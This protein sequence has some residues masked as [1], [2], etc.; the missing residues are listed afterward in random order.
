M[1]KRC[2]CLKDVHG[3][4]KLQILLC[5]KPRLKKMSKIKGWIKAIPNLLVNISW[6]KIKGWLISLFY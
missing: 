5:L 1:P 2:A 4:F 6:K 3:S